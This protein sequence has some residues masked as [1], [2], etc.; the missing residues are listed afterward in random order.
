MKTKTNTHKLT[1]TQTDLKAKCI[2]LG[3]ERQLIV[4]VCV[5]ARI[6]WKNCLLDF[7]RRPDTLLTQSAIRI[8]RHTTVNSTNSLRLLL[9]RPFTCLLSLT[10]LLPTVSRAEALYVSFQNTDTIMKFTMGGSGSF[11]AQT[12]LTYPNGFPDAGSPLMVW[13]MFMSPTSATTR[14]RNLPPAASP[15]CSA[16]SSWPTI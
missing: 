7:S 10:L 12:G 11:F 6:R 3:I 1:T 2:K 16:S 13:E 5:A 9:A 8:G 15:H 4:T 14:W